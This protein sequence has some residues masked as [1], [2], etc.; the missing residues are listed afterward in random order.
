MFERRV[1]M[2]Y[3]EKQYNARICMLTDVRRSRKL[4][5]H[6]MPEKLC[7]NSDLH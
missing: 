7:S 6:R 5:R 1:V 2:D 4:W 3:L